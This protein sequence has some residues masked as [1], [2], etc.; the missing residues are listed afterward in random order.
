MHA[1]KP[2]G[3]SN[4]FIAGLIVAAAAFVTWW[5]EGT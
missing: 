3:P 4:F 1:R 2:L 5:L